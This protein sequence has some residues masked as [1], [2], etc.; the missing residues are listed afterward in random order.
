MFVI[1]H[2]CWLIWSDHWLA[3]IYP[4]HVRYNIHNATCRVRYFEE[5]IITWSSHYHICG[6]PLFLSTSTREPSVRYLPYGS[7][8]SVIDGEFRPN[9][10]IIS[11]S[12][13][14]KLCKISFISLCSIFK[15]F[16]F[17][18]S[19]SSDRDTAYH[20][21]HIKKFL[22]LLNQMYFKCIL[23]CPA[24]VRV[25]SFKYNCWLKWY[26]RWSDINYYLK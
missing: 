1:L 20:L 21:V 14:I 12:Y 3:V 16:S 15:L 7:N 5:S 10:P 18:K 25:Y 17:R 26:G 19:W 6:N 2:I 11:P 23:E 8:I 22:I 13:F 24:D 9:G 4:L